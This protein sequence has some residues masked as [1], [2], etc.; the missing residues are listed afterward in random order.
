MASICVHCVLD[1]AFITILLLLLLVQMHPIFQLSI[2][3]WIL[4]VLWVVGACIW[5]RGASD[6]VWCFA[7]SFLTV[8]SSTAAVVVEVAAIHLP[9]LCPLKM[10]HLSNQE[11]LWQ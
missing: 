11:A 2:A 4:G 6:R 1:Q 5:F 8:V 9:F 7:V 3:D 10:G